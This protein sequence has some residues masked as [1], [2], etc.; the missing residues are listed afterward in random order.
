M[1]RETCPGCGV[2]LAVGHG[3]RHAYLGGSPSC[4]A[5]YGEVLARDYSDPARRAAHRTCVD[6]Y[7]AQHPGR[8]EPRTIRSAHVHLLGLHL[9]LER[10]WP[11]TAVRAAMARV[12]AG[13]AGGLRWLDPPTRYALTVADVHRT[14]DAAEHLRVVR[15]WGEAVWRAWRPHHRVVA[16]LADAVSLTR[17]TASR[18]RGRTG[19][20]SAA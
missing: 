18:S 19:P 1:T 2:V 14:S 4:W 12:S 20:P 3:P 17:P 16:D 10:G 13:D 5:L 15:A 11:E 8:P 9:T 7:A 6:A